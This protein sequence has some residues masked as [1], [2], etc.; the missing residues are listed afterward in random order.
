MIRTKFTAPKLLK[1]LLPL[2]FFFLLAISYQLSVKIVSAQDCTNI[3]NPEFNSLRPY[4]AKPCNPTPT[5]LSYSCGNTLVVKDKI[6]VPL[7][8]NPAC[9]IDYNAKTITCPFVE[10]RNLSISVDTT[11]SQLPIAGNTELVPNSASNLSQLTPADRVNEYLSWYLNGTTNRAEEPLDSNDV[12]SLNAIINFSGPIK[13]LLPQAIQYKQQIDTI[14]K[15]LAGTE[16]HDQ[17]VVCTDP[18]AN[19]IPCYDGNGTPAKGT[20]YR[21]SSWNGSLSLVNT[22]INS[23]VGAL[24]QIL[25]GVDKNLINQLIGDHWNKKIPPLPWD[26]SDPQLYLK[27]YQ[28]W[29]GK[30]CVLVPL[31]ITG[32][33]LLACVS[34][35]LVPKTYAELFPYIPFS[36]TE[37]LKGSLTVGTPQQAGGSDVNITNITFTGDNTTTLYFPHLDETSQLAGTLQTTYLPKD[38]GNSPGTDIQPPDYG[39][40]CKVLEVRSNSGDKLYG[41][42]TLGNLTY[43]ASFNCTFS[44]FSS[45]PSSSPSAC[46]KNAV[47]A[48]DI[49]IQTPKIDDIWTKLVG[50]E[51]SAFRRIFPKLGSGGLGSLTDIPA[52]TNAN[53]SSTADETSPQS[54]ELYI[55]HLGGVYEYFLKGIQTILRPKG[56]GEQVLTGVS[57]P[58]CSSGHTGD[59]PNFPTASGSCKLSGASLPPTLIKIIE[60]AAQ[61]YKVPPSLIYGV[62][63]GEGAFNPG[64]YDWTEQ[65]VQNWARSCTPMPGCNPSVWPSQGPVPF[66]QQDW[67]A[68]KDASKGVDPNREPNAC[69]LVDIVFALA[70]DLKVNNGSSNFAGKSCF[71]ISLKAGGASPNSCSWSNS[72]TETAIKIW[73]TGYLY[74][75]LTKEGSCAAGGGLNAECP[76]GDNC[77]T[78]NNRYSKPSHNACIWDVYEKF[79]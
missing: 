34:N 42:K 68:L 63:Y 73:E 19:P 74:A 48:S 22:A 33:K 18:N 32:Q 59:I 62:M 14:N 61:A 24:S 17:I 76:G 69:N 26:F 29:H 2:L 72:D 47:L 20:S 77:E 23:I 31:P 36:S 40:G 44:I 13:K 37:D 3:T 30:T 79:K 66:Y 39:P 55:P 41:G 38:I 45:S 10:Q 11:Q 67:E 56:Y 12:S 9:Q 7:S 75:C 8:Y 60:S 35:P 50:G 4:P 15:A 70:K 57:G 46:T 52:V 65:N 1:Y 27:A 58:T 71:G 53:Y 43:T 21:L 78:I 5:D 51:A 64:K 16:R 49:S 25:P 6:T 54:A 28:E